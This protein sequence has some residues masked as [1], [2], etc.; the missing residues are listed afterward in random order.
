MSTRHERL[1]DDGASGRG[2]AP[3]TFAIIDRFF[4]GVFRHP[5]F[6]RARFAIPIHFVEPPED[7]EGMAVVRSTR[8]SLRVSAA[9]RSKLYCQ[10]NGDFKRFFDYLFA[11]MA[12]WD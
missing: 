10:I 4:K 9:C 2:S 8:S 6:G 5:F 3:T 12:A 1:R 11:G 7:F